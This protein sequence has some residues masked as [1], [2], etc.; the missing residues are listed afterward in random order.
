MQI[1]KT[2]LWSHLLKIY[3]KKVLNIYENKAN[4]LRLILC[5]RL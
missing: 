1:Q 3:P 2:V 5:C 4:I